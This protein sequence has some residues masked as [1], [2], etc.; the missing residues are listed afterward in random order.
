MSAI[1][2][3]KVGFQVQK[4][5]CYIRVTREAVSFNTSNEVHWKRKHL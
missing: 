3:G 2:V 4:D 5:A 1:G